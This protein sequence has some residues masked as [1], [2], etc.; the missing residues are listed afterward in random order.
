MTLE[1]PDIRGLSTVEAALAYADAGWY[2]G[3]TAPGNRKHPGSEL[4]KGWEQK[5]SRSAGDI[6]AW[7][8]PDHDGNPD[9]GL[10]L[11]VG[12]S[13]A[14]AFDVDHPEALPELLN[15]TLMGS[16]A[17]LALTRRSPGTWPEDLHPRGHRLLR[18][19]EGMV[20]GNRV[21]PELAT[22][23]GEVRG[24]NG[25][26]VVAPTLHPEHD[27]DGEYSW[28]RIGP[29]PEL[30]SW[31]REVFEAQGGPDEK[32]E[33]DMAEAGEW[34][35]ATLRPGEPSRAVLEVLE[36]FRQELRTGS[37]HEAV[38]RAQQR[39][40]RLGEK[41]APG[42]KETLERVGYE[43][44]EAMG[45]D[46]DGGR[47]EWRRGLLGAVAIVKATP[48]ENLELRTDL[49]ELM[50]APGTPR[51][52]AE[53]EERRQDQSFWDTTPVLQRVRD[54]ARARR[55][56]PWGLLGACLAYAV[57]YVE[58]HV[59]LPPLVGSY[60]SLNL[61]VALVAPS[62]GGKSATL[63]AAAELMQPVN[64]IMAPEPPFICSI[65][66]GEA[67]THV[68]AARDKNAE[69]GVVQ[70]RRRALVKFDELSQLTGLKNRTGSTII[71]TLCSAWSG[72]RL[73][74]MTA[75]ESRRLHVAAHAYRLCLIGGVQP[76]T[77]DVLLEEEG[78][79]LPQRFL[80]LPTTDPDRPKQ[81]PPEPEGLGWEPQVS[82]SSGVK[83]VTVCDAVVQAVDEATEARLDG[84]VGIDGHELQTRIK[85]AAALAYLHNQ[86]EVSDFWWRLSDVVM[87]KSRSVRDG[88]AAE[89]QARLAREREA[90]VRES[91]E[92]EMAKEEAA[93]R[94]GTDAAKRRILA[95]LQNGEAS[96]SELRR[97]ISSKYRGYADQA[98]DEL[99][100][101]GLITEH[102]ARQGGVIYRLCG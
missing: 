93:D 30:P 84:R 101:A 66:S 20:I 100:S 64:G 36:L 53:A 91:V 21:P 90:R 45:T 38:N 76:A 96:R 41:G 17:P 80:W 39:L 74:A 78:T 24:L 34:L 69:D 28:A 18:V 51:S 43:F 94:R 27:A 46:R 89:K 79:G 85:V 5:T 4:G 58:P 13:G 56:G 65:A 92:A 70:K 6:M 25:V 31:L 88:L 98:L 7:F 61:F 23:W 97:K 22:G 29:V 35:D 72:G 11:H 82:A 16:R 59:Q 8:D 40:V 12:R 87:A 1:V 19:P 73:G 95:A 10:F 37:R 71:P 49:T 99:Y 33:L 77:V 52:L 75:D 26:I 86:E 32:A 14:V 42:V 81:R 57:A 54:F 60:G 44:F 15:T 68:Y 9:R 47:D 2:V 48:T 3:P 50:P 102:R 63:D 55:V 62:S 67:L 83:A